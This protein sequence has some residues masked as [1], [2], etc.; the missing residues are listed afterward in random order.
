M[1]DTVPNF[2]GLS[3]PEIIP[4]G[5]P[6]HWIFTVRQIPLT[7]FGD[8]LFAVHP[9]SHFMLMKGPAPMLTSEDRVVRAETIVPHL[10]QTFVD[11]KADWSTVSDGDGLQ[12]IAPWTWAT[13]DTDLA[14]AISSELKQPG[15]IEALC[16][17][18][19]C[20]TEE[21]GLLRD[22][23]SRLIGSMMKILEKDARRAR[24][25]KGMAAALEELSINNTEGPLICYGCLRDRTALPALLKRCT[26]PRALTLAKA[27][28]L[29]LPTGDGT[30]EGTMKP[31]RRLVVTGKDTP[32]NL[33]L[34]F[35]P[36]WEYTIK[37]SHEEARIE[38]LLDPPTGSPSYAMTANAGFGSDAPAWSPRPASEVESRK[39]AEVT[40]MQTCIRQHLGDRKEPTNDDMEAIVTPFGPACVESVLWV[41]HLA[42]KT[43]DRGVMP[44]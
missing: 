31:I 32:E 23:W 16:S 40:E 3:R 15:A 30:S 35:G 41:Y 37:A 13:D 1:D 9:Q 38:V 33:Q 21:R 27:V 17:V 5:R 28:N 8:L 4:S 29:T 19:T 39:V 43:M 2:N 44:L 24:S 7:L 36:N 42:V 22:N 11:Y 12:A 25:R 14:N 18:G 6:N 26:G 10:L 34:F 20:S